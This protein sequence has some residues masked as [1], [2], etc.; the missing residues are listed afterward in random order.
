M[1]YLLRL[2]FEQKLTKHNGAITD[3]LYF[4]FYRTK[5][6]KKIILLLIVSISLKLNAQNYFPYS[7]EFPLEFGMG[8]N[9]SNPSEPK[10]PLLVSKAG[11]Y[12]D[13]G[14]EISVTYKLI[15]SYES[16]NK[17]FG[18]DASLN[19]R[20]LFKKLSANFQIDDKYISS[21]EYQTLVFIAKSDF[22]NKG[23]NDLKLKPE[24]QKLIDEKNYDD[25]IER[26]GTHF[27]QKIKTGVSFYVFFSFKK[28]FAETEDIMEGGAS[29]SGKIL[30]GEANMNRALS[31]ASSAGELHVEIYSNGSKDGLPTFS[32]ILTSSENP[33]DSVKSVIS[34]HLKTF[35]RENSKSLGY[36]YSPMSL[37]GVP[38]DKV[39]WTANREENLAKIKGEYLNTISNIEALTD[40]KAEC[41][42][43]KTTQIQ[44]DKYENILTKFSSYKDSLVL[45]HKKCLDLNEKYYN[46][47]SFKPTNLEDE[48]EKL[49]EPMAMI[50]NRKF[51]DTELEQG[52][53]KS[54]TFTETCA[55]DN[56]LKIKFSGILCKHPDWKDFSAS[57]EFDFKIND[58]PFAT[59]KQNFKG[60]NKININEVVPLGTLAQM[61]GIQ[62][63]T[64]TL[65][66]QIDV[67]KIK[68][69]K[70]STGES[71]KGKLPI[72][73]MTLKIII[74]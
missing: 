68:L 27:V 70:I 66:F 54:W 56:D 8:F 11:T 71:Y 30:G 18:A 69:V 33:I 17:E 64:Q 51:E 48:A 61:Y 20:I 37:L 38:K 43:K 16:F 74:E 26:Y 29:A 36:Y 44:K 12:E 5:N 52:Y 7:K 6:M 58:V 49:V 41:V 2:A 39:T 4:C 62:T 53:I 63:N 22:G 31:K 45:Y 15:D 35:T 47:F 59:V 1:K 50:L 46:D 72:S 14:A 40:F 73:D 24:A 19:A 60:S 67:K 32:S 9:I 65:K 10:A 21:S 42:Y 23:L 28:S 34:R 3:L 13:N 57:I 55:E 25:F